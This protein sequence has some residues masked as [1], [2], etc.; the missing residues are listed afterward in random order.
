VMGYCTK[1][2]CIHDDIIMMYLSLSPYSILS[3][4]CICMCV[5][6]CETLG[7]FVEEDYDELS[8]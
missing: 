6:N 3:R 8:K 2:H 1:L 4:F 5:C 7:N